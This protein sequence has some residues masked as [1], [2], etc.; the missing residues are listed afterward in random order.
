MNESIL[1]RQGL[2]HPVSA[3]GH[4]EKGDVSTRHDPSEFENVFLQTEAVR[5]RD[6]VSMVQERGR[7][8]VNG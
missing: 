2:V 8:R 1:V 7:G 6:A 4:R 5:K 3:P